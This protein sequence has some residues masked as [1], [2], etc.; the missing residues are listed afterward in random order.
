MDEKLKEIME[1]YSED[2]QRMMAEIEKQLS[3]DLENDEDLNQSIARAFANFDAENRAIVIEAVVDAAELGYGSEVKP[4]IISLPWATDNINLSERLH[5]TSKAIR[6]KVK[7]TILAGMQNADSAIEISRKL[8]DGYGQGSVI[9]QAEMPKYLDSIIRSVSLAVKGDNVNKKQILD[10][11][12]QIKHDV[13]ELQS[14]ALK[15]SYKELLSSL[16]SFKAE[17]IQNAIKVAVEE[18]SRYQAERIARTETA[19]A[20]FEGY[21]A[22]YADDDDVWGYKWELSSN[23]PIYDQCNV[24]ANAD[25]G[26]GKGRYPKKYMPSIPLH[27]HCRCHLVPVFVW[28]VESSRKPNPK[29]MRQYIDGLTTKEKIALFGV[30]GFNQYKQGT[31]WQELLRGWNGFSNPLANN[32]FLT[33]EE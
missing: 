25:M 8:Y 9:S 6:Q 15:A 31:D 27:P 19:R 20:W 30:K 7:D 1:Q 14:N 33:E 16:E 13:S 2:F 5:G 22:R 29:Q 21:V 24:C 12:Q 28:Q 23:H 26:Y 17:A 32:R 11:I 4:E 10:R 18:K 3:E